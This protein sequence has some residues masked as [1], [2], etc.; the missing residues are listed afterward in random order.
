MLISILGKE[1][2]HPAKWHSQFKVGLGLDLSN[3]TQ[4]VLK[5]VTPNGQPPS[6][7]SMQQ[8]I[9]VLE[10]RVNGTG[11]SGAQVQQQGSD[12]INVTVPGKAAQDVIDLVS[13]TATPTAS[14][15][16]KATATPKAGSTTPTASRSP[17][18]T[19]PAAASAFGDPSKVNAETKK[20]FDKLV[21]KPGPNPNTVDDSWKATVGYTLGQAQ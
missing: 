4:V 1:T 3:G 16:A 14:T 19:A 12:L 15:S 17:S 18:S 2:F 5:A 8:A 7:G 21:C 20:L 6:S 11:N 13:A 9:S 10:S